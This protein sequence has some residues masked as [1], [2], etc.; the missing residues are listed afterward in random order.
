MNVRFSRRTILC[1]LAILAVSAVGCTSQS[2]DQ[3]GTG[4]EK[5][6]VVF[7]QCN[8]SEPYRAAQNAR[9]KELWGKQ[10][11]VELV[12][13][14]AQ[15][16]NSRQI[17]QI[18]TAILRKPALLIVA[19]NEREPLTAVMG[20][21]MA[22]GIPTICLERDIVEPNYTTFISADNQAIGKLVGQ[23]IVDYL[24]RKNG[25]P[26][27][28]VVHIC[29]LEGVEAEH[30]RKDGAMEVLGKHPEIKIVAEPVA[31]WLQSR[32]RE[33]M[34]EV[35]ASNAEID[36]VYGHND[37]MA[38]G[39]YLAAKETGRETEMIFIGIDGLGDESGGI[40][41]VRD[42]ILA[43]TFIYP[44]CV[45]K[46]VEVGEKLINDP[47]F[48]PEKQYTLESEAVTPDSLK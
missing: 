35:L 4:A 8:N 24:T 6:L 18:E 12:I 34:A 14:D 22:A 1:Q 48:K 37:P 46:A 41:Q 36:V 9:M 23:F 44:L 5:K 29:G 32:A 28:N 26:A 47:N 31:D 45:D 39:A 10:P 19:P 33:R 40:Q 7:S 16:D 21:A 11:N 20:K 43:A 30:Q 13:D 25:K 3:A 27:G 15:Q 38:V 2:S 17:S 42:G